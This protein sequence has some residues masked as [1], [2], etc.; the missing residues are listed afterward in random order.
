MFQYNPKTCKMLY[1]LCPIG[2]IVRRDD[3]ICDVTDV[4]GEEKTYPSFDEALCHFTRFISWDNYTRHTP[5]PPSRTI[6][7]NTEVCQ[8][9]ARV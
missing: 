7:K 6:R 2:T 4:R 1:K 8:R 5:P 3:G 9:F